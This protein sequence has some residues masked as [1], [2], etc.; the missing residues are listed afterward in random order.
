[1]KARI[2]RDAIA[3][4]AIAIADVVT[5]RHTAHPTDR[6]TIAEPE[7]LADKLTE[8]RDRGERP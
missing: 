2:I 5:N 7:R 4:A 8:Q 1:M 6:T 3:A